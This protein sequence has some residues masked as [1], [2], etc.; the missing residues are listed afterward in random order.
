MDFEPTARATEHLARLQDFMDAHVYPAEPVYAAQRAE[1][2]AAGTPHQLPA[3]VEELKTEARRRDLWNLFLPA[4]SGLTNVEYAPLAELMG[5]SIELAPEA[6]NCAAPDTGNMEILHMFG[7]PEQQEQWLRPLL[8]G[9]IRSAFA[10]TE[11]D[12]ASSDATNISTRIER[13]GDSYVINGRKWWTTGIADPRCKIM[14]LMGKTD[15]S[16]DTHRQQSMVLVPVDTPGVQ[17][18]RSLPV[19]GYHDQHGH[20]EVLFTDVRV[21]V[22]N[23]LGEEGGGFALAQ[24]RLG[25][26]RIHHCMRAIGLAERALEL[27]VRRAAS[28]VAFGRSLA[29]QGVVQ[30]QIAESRMAIEQARL[31]TLKAAWMIDRYGT[32]AART[33]IAAIKVIAPR[34]ALD[35]LDRAIQ[36]HGGAGVSDDVPLAGMYAGARTLRI[37]DGPDEVHVR[38]VARREIRRR[39]EPR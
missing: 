13:D 17:V 7:T 9:Q 14:I 35:V 1:L 3:V 6:T 21:P 36:V 2:A 33:E 30:Q 28:R 10:M 37:A 26:G 15:P 16:A 4:L 25:P 27:M 19:F 22:G 11:P 20:G 39:L 23:L 12:V 31:L 5:R 38:D 34:V 18:L 29:E 8:D 24:A 32:K